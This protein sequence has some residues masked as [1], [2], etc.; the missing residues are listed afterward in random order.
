MLFLRKISATFLFEFSRSLTASRI[1]T[2]LILAFFAP[3]ML[4]LIGF[5]LPKTVESSGIPYPLLVLSV[6]HLLAVLLAVL[7]WATPVV[8]SELEGKTWAYLA[9]RPHG[10]LCS[11][12]G[13]YFNAVFWA[14]ATASVSLGLS[15]LVVNYFPWNFNPAV[16]GDG[17]TMGQLEMLKQSNRPM[18]VFYSLLPCLFLGSMAFSA[19]FVHI[20]LIS[21]KRGMILAVVYGIVETIFAF[22]PAIVRQFTVG[23]HLRNIGFKIADFN[24]NDEFP[25]YVTDDSGTGFHILAVLAITVVHVAAAIYWLHAREYITAEEA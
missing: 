7:L 1:S 17:V 22:L 25:D 16:F 24:L 18:V 5:W 4:T 15:C 8:F 6:F 23:F 12:L 9:I 3:I 20:G 2:S 21:H 19:I 10:K 13:K 11:T 14:S